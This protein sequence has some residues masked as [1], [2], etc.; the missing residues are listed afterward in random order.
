[1]CVF[2]EG[3]GGEVLPPRVLKTSPGAEISI[4]HMLPTQNHIIYNRYGQLG[5]PV[6]LNPVTSSN[7]PASGASTLLTM[8]TAGA[9]VYEDVATNNVSRFGPPNASPATVG[10]GTWNSRKI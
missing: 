9:I 8:F 7:L 3:E 1:M 4:V 6:V 5:A 10:T 2:A